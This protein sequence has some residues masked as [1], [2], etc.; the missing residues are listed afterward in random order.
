MLWASTWERDAL[1]VGSGNQ[2]AVVQGSA[3]W[4]A[5]LTQRMDARVRQFTGTGATVVMLTQPPFYDGGNPSSPTP[6][7]FDFE[8]LNSLINQFA[9]HTPDVRVVNLAARVCPSG[10]PCPLGVGNVWVRGDGAHYTSQ[11]SLWVAR[12]LMPQL[13]IKALQRPLTPLPLITMV[14]PKDGVTVT[15]STPLVA[16]SPFGFGVAKV[17]FQATGTAIGKVV[18]G[19]AA[20]QDGQDG[21]WALYW[22]TTDVPPGTYEVRAIAYDSAGDRSVSKEAAVRVRH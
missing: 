21:L 20:L 13:G 5:V 7:D 6:G 19:P 18:I 2:T 16:T 15:G 12:W 1:A 4:Y 11:G 17:E 14:E 9:S 22:N 3:Q 8:R 10:P